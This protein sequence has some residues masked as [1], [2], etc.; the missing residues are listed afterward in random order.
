M[1]GP[2]RAKKHLGQHFLVDQNIARKISETLSFEGYDKVLEI[3]PGTGVL[4][5][6]LIETGKPITL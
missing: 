6:F 5:K 3:G 2:V 1:S 4:T